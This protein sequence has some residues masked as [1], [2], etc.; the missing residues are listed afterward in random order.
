MTFAVSIHKLHL[1]M[2]PNQNVNNS[3]RRNKSGRG[4]AAS[5]SHQYRVLIP[6]ASF[7]CAVVALMAFKQHDTA[8]KFAGY[9]S[10]VLCIGS[11]LIYLWFEYIDRRTVHEAQLSEKM[12]L[13]KSEKRAEH[14]AQR[15]ADERNNS[16]EKRRAQKSRID[17]DRLRRAE[18][19][20]RERDEEHRR[21]QHD[22]NVQ[23]LHNH[24]LCMDNSHDLL[25]A[26][27]DAY[28]TRFTRI[29]ARP[30]NAR[31]WIAQNS[32]TDSTTICSLLPHHHQAEVLDVAAIIEEADEAGATNC[33]LISLAGFSPA[34]VQL[35]ARNP[36]LTLVDLHM[37]A[38][39]LAQSGE[40]TE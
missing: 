19:I 18:R 7:I 17:M 25:R 1:T 34:C 3:R 36:E 38:T 33:H 6:A 9:V 20:Q 40:I 21:V 22:A 24:L 10:T 11:I 14:K 15:R 5:L 30:D 23:R 2:S 26:V 35:A 29:E 28:H 12:Q 4:A 16:E 13:A 31:I 39:W 37:I 32:T 27:N 8:S